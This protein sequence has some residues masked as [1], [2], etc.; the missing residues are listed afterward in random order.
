MTIYSWNMFFENKRLDRALAL[1]T[2]SD[3]DVFCLQEVPEHFLERL[4]TLELH[5]AYQVDAERRTPNPENLYLVILSKHPIHRAQRIPFPDYWPQLPARARAFIYLMRPL[6]FARAYNR[7]G[8]YVDLHIGERVVRVFN[9]HLLLM[10]PALRLKEFELV[11]LE[12]NQ[13][14]PA[15]ICGDF[16]ILEKPHITILNWL[17]GGSVRD[18]FPHR[19]ERTHIEKRFVE[20]ALTNVLCGNSTHPLSRSQLDH[21]L[22]S[23]SFTIKEAEVLPD[24][25]GSDHHP[26]RVE[27]A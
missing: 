18:I 7:G 9:V 1:I 6:H 16:N 15:I 22:V 23:R 11:M 10:H 19:R 13:E 20:H 14:H 26:I 27:V 4:K 3:F 21:I 24:R 12:R 25:A 17:F 8:L 2:Q 5:I